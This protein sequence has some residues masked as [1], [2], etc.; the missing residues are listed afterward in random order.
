MEHVHSTD[1]VN[2]TNFASRMVNPMPLAKIGRGGFKDFRE[3]ALKGSVLDMAIGIILGVAFGK[4]ITS[5]VEDIVMPVI[6]RIFGKMDFS[7]MFVSLTGKHFDTMAAAKATGAPTLNYG[8]FMNAI[9]NFAI[10]AIGVFLLVRQVNRFRNL[11]TVEMKECPF[12]FSGIM[13]KA[14]RCPH[15][16]SM[17]EDSKAQAAT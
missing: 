12:C 5:F 13:K 8:V 16:T 17:M 6:S 3:F 4:I 14:T 2:I 1:P 15:C 9:L 11:Q 10:V 7:N